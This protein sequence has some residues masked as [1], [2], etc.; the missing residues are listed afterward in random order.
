LPACSAPQRRS[1][2]TPV[3][4]QPN[5]HRDPSL[6]AETL[7]MLASVSRSGSP[8]DKVSTAFD[9]EGLVEAVDHVTQLLRRTSQFGGAGA[10]IRFTAGEVA[11]VV[12]GEVDRAVTPDLDVLLASVIARGRPNVGVGPGVGRV[13]GR[14]PSPRHRQCGGAAQP[15]WST[16]QCQVAVSIIASSSRHLRNDRRALCGPPTPPGAERRPIAEELLP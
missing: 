12:S 4:R 14:R 7:I 16:A 9:S 15:D 6:V 13:H 8:A 2:T 3:S 11:V 1:S 10:F 5:L